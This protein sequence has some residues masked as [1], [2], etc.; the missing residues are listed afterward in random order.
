[1]AEQSLEWIDIRPHENHPF[2]T[3]KIDG[4]EKRARQI[5]S[6]MSKNVLFLLVSHLERRVSF[7]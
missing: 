6:K 3:K 4:F 5:A 7:C 2:P 1:L